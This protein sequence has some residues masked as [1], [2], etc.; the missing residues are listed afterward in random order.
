MFFTH[1][2]QRPRMHV[3]AYTSNGQSDFLSA[4]AKQ[5]QLFPPPLPPLRKMS[6]CSDSPSVTA[7]RKRQKNF[8]YSRKFV[9]PSFFFDALINVCS[10][11]TKVNGG[12][13]ETHILG[14]RGKKIAGGQTTSEEW[15]LLLCK[16]YRLTVTYTKLLHTSK[17]VFFSRI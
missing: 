14:G 4:Q 11:A 6:D 12:E 16:L 15:A 3:C 5:N 8:L 1:P 13:K 9:P 2:V 7:I 17:K 10:K